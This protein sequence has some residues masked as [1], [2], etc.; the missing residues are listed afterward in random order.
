MMATVAVLGE[1]ERTRRDLTLAIEE[2]GHRVAAASGIPDAME[3][4]AQVRPQLLVV[5]CEPASRLAEHALGEVDRVQPLLPVIVA[6]EKRSAVRAVDLMKAGA[7]EV[8]APPWT[9]ENLSAC[10]AK[11]LRFKG[12]VFESSPAPGE[13][14]RA[15]V[16]WAGLAVFLAAAGLWRATRPRPQAPPP[17]ATR[18]WEL[19]YSHPAGLC[20]AGGALWVSDW[21]AETVYR[22]DPKTVGVRRAVHLPKEMPGAVALTKDSLWTSSAGS[23]VRHMIDERLTGLARVPDAAGPTIAMAYDGLYLWTIDSKTR[24][25][26]KRLLDDTLTVLDS[27]DYPGMEP[28]ALAWDG[29]NLWSI[30]AGN[31]EL[32]RHG[33]QHP[34]EVTLRV[35][36]PEYADGQW[37]PVGLAYDGERFWT[38]AENRKN[39]AAPGRIFRHVLQPS[40]GSGRAAGAAP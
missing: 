19:P 24:R 16:L 26:H 6:L 15:T 12:T 27:Y 9:A 20:F 10:L 17:P 14:R 34:G 21:Y 11:A 2:L 33:L 13:R 3:M 28:A 37:R 1:K 18:A 35:S 30:D 36:L 22:L 23:L 29:K 32:V 8:I 4:L 5:A 7:Y 31:K 40:T 25:I 39:I 38:V